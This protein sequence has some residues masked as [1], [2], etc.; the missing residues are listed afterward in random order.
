PFQFF[1][2]YFF[3]QGIG[4]SAGVVDQNIDS[5][6][7]IGGLPN[8]SFTSAVLCQIRCHSCNGPGLSIGI[9]FVSYLF[10]QVSFAARQQQ[11]SSQAIE[12]FGDRPPD[13]ASSTSHQGRFSF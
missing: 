3:Q 12:L 5:S 1:F 8:D 13:P 4:K 6:E 10:Q 9:Q 11:V 2:L 7:G